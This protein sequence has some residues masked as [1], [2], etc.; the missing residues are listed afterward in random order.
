[1]REEDKESVGKGREGK[2]GR[3][4]YS[5]RTRGIRRGEAEGGGSH[6]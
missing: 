2:E 6:L 3:R 1:M 5:H 4:E